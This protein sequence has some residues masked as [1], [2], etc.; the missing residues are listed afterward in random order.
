MEADVDPQRAH[1][2]AHRVRCG[3]I[4]TDHAAPRGS[5]Y[6]W[7]LV[8]AAERGRFAVA[9]KRLYAHWLHEVNGGY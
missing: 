2:P 9:P 8:D 1:Q 4:A 3:S 7:K 5:K 6:Q